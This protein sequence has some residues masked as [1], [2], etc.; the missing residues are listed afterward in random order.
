MFD[1]DKWT[2]ITLIVLFLVIGISS[3]FETY[4]KSQEKIEAIKACYAANQ[5]NCDK[6]WK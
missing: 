2:A 1:I 6:I 4:Q 3:S 5:P